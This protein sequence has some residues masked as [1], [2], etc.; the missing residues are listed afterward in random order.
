MA[1]FRSA[2][3]ITAAVTAAIGL[4]ATASARADA[5]ASRP[6]ASNA[7]V[8]AAAVKV[9]QRCIGIRVPASARHSDRSARPR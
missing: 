6:I 7:A 5:V 2:V 8:A 3:A 1:P 9:A 4:L